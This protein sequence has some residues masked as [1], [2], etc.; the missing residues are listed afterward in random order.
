MDVMLLWDQA[1]GEPATTVVLFTVLR[2]HRNKPTQSET[3]KSE[4]V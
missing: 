3:P 4:A 2:L 1:L